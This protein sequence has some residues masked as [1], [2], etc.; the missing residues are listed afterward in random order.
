MNKPLHKFFTD[1]HNRLDKLLNKATENPDE[2]EM[3]YYHQFR[4]GLLRHIKMEEKTLF[5]AAKKVNLELM[6]KLIPRY[7]LDHGALT[8]LMV[9]PPTPT[10]IRVIRHLLEIHDLA[11]EEPGGL[12]DVCEELTHG[13]TEE[14]LAQLAL[15]EEVPVH[16]PNPAPIAIESARRALER[17]G[18]DF[19]EIAGE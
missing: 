4:T 19:D 3:N 7:R 1:D 15:I 13:Q 5:P 8:S 6:Q 12:Y 11:E 14:L 2:I 18:Y 16:P 10:L 17:A 9:P